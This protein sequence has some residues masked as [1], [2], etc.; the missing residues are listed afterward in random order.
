MNVQPK[1]QPCYTCAFNLHARDP[2]IDMVCLNYCTGVETVRSDGTVKKCTDYAAQ[3]E[4][5]TMK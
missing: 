5:S 2:E 1:N 4:P 3:A